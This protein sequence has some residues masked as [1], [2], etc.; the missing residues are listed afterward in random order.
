V[1]EPVVELTVFVMVPTGAVLATVTFTVIVAVAPAAN[2]TVVFIADVD[3]PAVAQLLPVGAL[4][5][6]DH[7]EN[8][9]V[10]AT[11]VLCVGK[12]SVM[13]TFVAVVAPVFRAVIVYA[14]VPLGARVLSATVFARRTVGSEI[15]LVT[16][17]EL[18]L[19]FDSHDAVGAGVGAPYSANVA[20]FAKLPEVSPGFTFAVTSNVA[21]PVDT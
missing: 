12:G 14:V 4:Q 2:V 13:L 21:V 11:G 6:H 9:G 10:P 1:G 17:T 18:S 15:G 19:L 7:D 5:V 3:G 16:V 20:V 8:Q